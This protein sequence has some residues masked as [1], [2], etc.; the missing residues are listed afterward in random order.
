MP[1]CA[2]VWVFALA[3]KLL[4]RLRGEIVPALQCVRINRGCDIRTGMAEPLADISQRHAGRQLFTKQ[5]STQ[6]MSGARPC[7]PQSPPDSFRTCRNA[8]Y[9]RDITSSRV[10]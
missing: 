5:T 8:V 4:P 10:E 3:L 9:L 2:P 1:S 7:S 6:K